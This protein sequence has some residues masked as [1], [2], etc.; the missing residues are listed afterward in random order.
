MDAIS[1]GRGLR[2]L[3]ERAGLSQ[4]RLAEAIGSNAASLSRIEAGSRDVLWSSVTR[5]LD[6]LGADLHYLADAIDE[7][8]EQPEQ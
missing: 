8:A 7:A 4:E 5:V 6:A 2:L 1:L 3:R